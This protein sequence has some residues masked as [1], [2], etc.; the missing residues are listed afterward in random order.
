MSQVSACFY[1]LPIEDPVFNELPIV[2]FPLGYDPSDED[3]R[4]A[5]EFNGDEARLSIVAKDP[6][7]AD[8][9]FI[10]DGLDAVDYE[11]PDPP[12][13]YSVNG[14]IQW[15][16]EVVIAD[17]TPLQ[18]RTVVTLLSDGHGDR[19]TIVRWLMEP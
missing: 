10:W 4:A 16:A 9:E 14:E 17:W 19:A 7:D 3:D 12:R 11:E 2:V 15:R 5:P 6:D 18:H 1:V 8:I 13:S